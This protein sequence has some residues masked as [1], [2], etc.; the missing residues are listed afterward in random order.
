LTI[1]LTID[2]KGRIHGFKITPG[3]IHDT[4][5]VESMTQ[6]L[7]GLLFGDRDYLSKGLFES[8]YKRGIKHVAT[9]RKN[10]KNKSLM[11]YEK[12]TLGSNLLLKLYFIY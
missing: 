9:I 5:A 7:Q 10:I 6:H 12:L 11:I 4:K 2:R 3:N 8:L 1:H